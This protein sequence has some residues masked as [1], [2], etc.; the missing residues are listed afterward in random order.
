M[1]AR[2]PIQAAPTAEETLC[3]AA[4]DES[5]RWTRVTIDV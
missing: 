2:P 3:V 5:N 1:L 4:R